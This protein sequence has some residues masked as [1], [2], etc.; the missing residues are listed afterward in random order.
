MRVGEAFRD[1]LGLEAGDGEAIGTK[2]FDD[3]L[4]NGGGFA[5][6]VV[7]GFRDSPLG[8]LRG[9]DMFAAA[10]PLSVVVST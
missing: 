5:V 8:L 4:R 9:A 6:G 7:D 2:L 10:L 1:V 3:C